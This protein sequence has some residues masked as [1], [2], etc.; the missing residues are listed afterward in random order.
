MERAPGWAKTRSISGRESITGMKK[1]SLVRQ[2]EPG[3][4]GFIKAKNKNISNWK[5]W[6]TV[7]NAS[8]WRRNG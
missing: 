3:D 5:E 2:E 6:S 4:W 8:G 1:E 7:L